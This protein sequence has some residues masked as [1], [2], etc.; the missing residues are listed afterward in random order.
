MKANLMKHCLAIAL[1]IMIVPCLLHSAE[2]SV[3]ASNK[4]SQATKP[5]SPVRIKIVF[6]PPLRGAPAVRIDGGSRG[7]GVS[8]ICLNVLAPDQTGFTTQEQPSLFWYQ[9]EPADVPF[10]ITLIVD[11]QP[12]P[13][14]QV[15][16]P[17]AKKA[18][19]QRLRL[20]DHNVKL[21]TG[22]EYEWVVALV[23]DPES[24][25][26]DVVASGFIKRVEPAAG[27][28]AR[29]ANASKTELPYIY[30]DEGI[31]YD[32]LEALSNELE[33]RPDDQSLR[34]EQATLLA[35]VGLTNAAAFAASSKTPRTSP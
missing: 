15:K 17:D 31:W 18:G 22:V 27:L 7:S 13:V 14:L 12:Q 32:A 16:L 6:K 34:A 2:P 1:F 20:S 28:S 10:E 25:S 3:V 5:S 4:Q 8:L 33:T 21:S 29:L 19:I 30:A 26:K 35:Q 9:S 24:R 11:K 23:P